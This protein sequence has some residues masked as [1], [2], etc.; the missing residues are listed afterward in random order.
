MWELLFEEDA[1]I[2]LI[3]GFK[4]SITDKMK[5]NDDDHNLAHG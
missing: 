1:K 5:K 2:I 4:I 3:E